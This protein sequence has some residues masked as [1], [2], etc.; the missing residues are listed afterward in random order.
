[1]TKRDRENPCGVCGTPPPP[2][3]PPPPKYDEEGE[4]CGACDQRWK[5][6]ERGRVPR[7]GESA[8][9]TEVLK[10]FLFLTYDNTSRSEVIWTLS[11][12]HILSL[13]TAR[14]ALFWMAPV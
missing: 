13:R 3:P 10:S 1:M 5:P 14:P 6:S 4:V 8:F 11:I 7:R 2:P 12:S 9:P